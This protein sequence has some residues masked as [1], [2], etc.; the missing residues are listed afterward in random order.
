M[1]TW[2]Y[3]PV[4]CFSLLF[5]N[6]YNLATP[7][8]VPVCVNEADIKMI[9]R[10]FVNIIYIGTTRSN[11]NNLIDTKFLANITPKFIFRGGPKSL[12]YI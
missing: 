2:I 9:V 10:L 11:K 8:V 1:S 4:H 7:C 3:A 6:I 12:G 5:P